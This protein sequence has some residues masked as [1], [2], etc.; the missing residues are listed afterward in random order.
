MS[1]KNKSYK[2]S[3]LE[4][5]KI[6]FPNALRCHNIHINK[7]IVLKFKKLLCFKLDNTFFGE[8][9]LSTYMSLSK[10]RATFMTPM[11][12]NVKSNYNRLQ[13]RFKF[14]GFWKPLF[15]RK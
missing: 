11:R 4:K 3:F 13:I 14:Y 9:S 6:I 12:I 15:C 10:R 1:L 7:K 5:K 2:V 8:T